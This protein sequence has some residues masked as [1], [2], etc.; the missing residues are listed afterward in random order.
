M[1]WGSGTAEFPYLVDPLSAITARANSDGSTIASSLSDSD[2]AAAATTAAGKDVALVFINA[3]S[4]EAYITVE[5]NAGDRNDL[6]AWHGGDALVQAVAG[7]N[8]N[9]VVVIHAAGAIVMES[10]INHPNGGLHPS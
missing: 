3:D 9:T 10:W 4:G 7:V 5:G 6:A 2:L 8:Q 1:G